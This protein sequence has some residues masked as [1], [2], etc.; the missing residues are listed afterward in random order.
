MDA[1]R[2]PGVDMDGS[3]RLIGGGARSPAYRQIT[4]DLWGS[5]IT[6]HDSDDL[7]AAFKDAAGSI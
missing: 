7:R 5:P 3:L 1:L 4:A 6:V 2:T